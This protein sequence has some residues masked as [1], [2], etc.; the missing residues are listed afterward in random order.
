MNRRDFEKERLARRSIGYFTED[1]GAARAGCGRQVRGALVKCF[2]GQKRK[3]EGFLGVLRN[4]QSRRGQDFDAGQSS[5]E[6]TEDQRI[7]RP[8]AGNN[9]LVNFRFG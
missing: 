3:G 4:A 6:L 5:G 1:R 8:A 2:V 7:V 9:E